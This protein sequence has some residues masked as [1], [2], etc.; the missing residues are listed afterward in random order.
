MSIEVFFS[1]KTLSTI[2]ALERSVFFVDISG[3]HLESGLSVEYFTAKL[4]FES[5]LSG[6][7]EEVR[8]ETSGLY[9]LFSTIRAFVRTDSGVDSHMPVECTLQ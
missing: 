6:V 1:G 7:V 8:F 3:V 5:I 4:A 2:S 9:E